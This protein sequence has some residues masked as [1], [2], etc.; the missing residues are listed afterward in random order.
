MRNE[1]AEN[2]KD[3]GSV[4]NWVAKKLEALGLKDGNGHHQFDVGYFN[5]ESGYSQY[6]KTALKG[7][8][9]TLNKT[10]SGKPDFHLECY[11]LPVVIEDKNSLKKLVSKIKDTIKNDDDSVKNFAVNGALYYAKNMISSG[12]YSDVVAIGVAGD[13]ESNIT[14][15][16][17]YVYGSG[18]D[19][20]KLMGDYKSF[21]FLQ[22]KKA[23]AKFHKEATLTEE[24]KH[25]I[26]IDSQAKLQ[27]YAGKLN[28]LMHNHNITAPQRVLYVSGMLLAMQDLNQNGYESLGITPEFLNGSPLNGNRDG[29]IVVNRVANY[30]Q[31]KQIPEDK[32]QLMLSSFNEISKDADRDKPTR[33]DKEVAKYI[34]GMASAN[35]QIFTFIYE[36]IYKSI[37]GM[38]GTLDIMGEMYF[39][40][41]KYALGDGKEIG[42]VLT[43]PYD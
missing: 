30:L 19:S 42:I 13:N 17:Y 3:E 12:G 27:S 34:N 39:E 22:N 40:F 32:R 9:K 29:Q 20:Q 14:L 25:K 5:H 31:L 10:N 37:D 24:E 26:L 35:K 4:N 16:V 18:P 21:D 11:D 1:M 15:E 8:A 2:Y 6:M 33:L 41:L 23:F 43:P 36:N 28:K 7:S 38:A